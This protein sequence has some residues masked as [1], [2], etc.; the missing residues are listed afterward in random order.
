MPV[1]RRADTVKSVVD[2]AFT[3]DAPPPLPSQTLPNFRQVT[4]FGRA[5]TTRSLYINRRRWIMLRPLAI[6]SINFNGPKD[7]PIGEA[8]VCRE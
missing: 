2:G 4:K 3:A 7:L 5:E 6:A 8:K 1:P